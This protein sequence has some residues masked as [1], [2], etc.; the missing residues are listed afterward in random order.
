[1]SLSSRELIAPIQRNGA[2]WI[3]LIHCTA[4]MEDWR[5]LLCIALQCSVVQCSAL[6]CNTE[7]CMQ[8]VGAVV[9]S[10]SCA[11]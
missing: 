7:Q 1:M 3:V 9:C 6:Q 11:L 8:C 4:H 2:Q 10:V 5:I